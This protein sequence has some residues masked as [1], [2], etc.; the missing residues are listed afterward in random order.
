M[1]KVNCKYHTDIPA[2]WACRNCQINYCKACIKDEGHGHDPHCPVCRQQLESLGSA[3]L[4]IPFWQRLGKFFLYPLHPQST[5]FLIVLT[6]LTVMLS[7]GLMGFLLY[8]VISIVFI[9]Y[10]YAVLEDTALGHLK[11]MPI[12]KG[13]INDEM[14]LPF[15]QFV[16]IAA[17]FAGNAAVL[18]NLGVFMFFISI[19]ITYLALPANIM[20]LAMEHSLFAALNPVIVFSVIRRIGAPYFLLYFLMFMLSVASATMMEILVSVFHIKIA[21]ALTIFTS[22][23]FSV[24]TFHLMGYTLYQYHDELGYTVDVEADEFDNKQKAIQES[25]NPELREIEILVQ[26]GSLEE[27]SKRIEAYIQQNPVDDEAIN[28]HIKLLVL[29]GNIEQLSKHGQ[30]YISTL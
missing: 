6:I 9:K 19:S 3:N 7:G 8:L 1:S 23:Y 25:V 22:M 27:A 21:Y 20:V 17:I 15:K 26:E 28:R 13:L 10:C 30:K 16:M 14:E 4:V 11:P 5:L 12:S 2:R 18:K 29:T 24:V